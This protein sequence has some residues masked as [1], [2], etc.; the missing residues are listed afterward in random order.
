MLIEYRGE[1]LRPALQDVK[2]AGYQNKGVDVYLFA[3]TETVVVDATE[4]LSLIHI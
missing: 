3:L 2:E 1:G 4:A